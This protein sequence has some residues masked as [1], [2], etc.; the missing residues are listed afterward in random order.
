MP[1]RRYRK[2]VFVD[3]LQFE[4][5]SGE[6]F[7]EHFKELAIFIGF[8]IAFKVDNEENALLR[9]ERDKLDVL[10]VAIGDYVLKDE[11]GKLRAM[12]KAEFEAEYPYL[13]N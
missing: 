10:E 2:D 5:M 3:A 4:G 12:K 1:V 13:V 9:I 7:S 8:P 11:S 6:R